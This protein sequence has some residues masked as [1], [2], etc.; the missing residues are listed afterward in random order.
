MCSR[1]PP[2]GGPRGHRLPHRSGAE[3]RRRSR[4]PRVGRLDA[5][6]RFRLRLGLPRRAAG[7]GQ[8]L[9]AARACEGSRR[10][11]VAQFVYRVL[12]PGAG[13]VR[14]GGD[15]RHGVGAR[16]S[17]AVCIARREQRGDGYIPGLPARSQRAG[18]VARRTTGRSVRAGSAKFRGQGRAADRRLQSRRLA[19]ECG[20]LAAD[21]RQRARRTDVV[22]ACVSASDTG[23]TAQS[24]RADRELGQ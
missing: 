10:V 2:L 21:Q 3:R 8:Q 11:F 18:R 24:H 4:H 17:T 12:A 7:E 13:S 22:V 23:Q 9:P 6:A 5:P 20:R 16:R 19:T 1:C 15:G 14:L